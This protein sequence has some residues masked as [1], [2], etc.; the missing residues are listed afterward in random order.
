[1]AK[2]I[3]V[4]GAGGFGREVLWTLE[5]I[6]EKEPLWNILGF[7]DDDPKL[8][9]KHVEGYPVL[10]SIE[11][12]D[13]DYPG[14]AVFIGLGDN[15]LREKLYRR[16]RGHDFPILVDPSADVA[17]ASDIRH[18]TFIGPRAVVSVGTKIGKLVIVNARAGVGH[19]STLGDFSQVSPGASLSG[20]TTIG[21][22]AFI[23]TNACTAPGVKI[24]N[25]AKIAAGTPVY[26]NVAD[27]ETLSPFGTLK[28][29]A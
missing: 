25:G 23:A 24:G 19:D 5:R 9:G 29:Q 1:M 27:G 11:Q 17:A 6:N 18:G 14:A 28:G 8:A 2:D 4:I 21:D 10:G 22:S 7:A 26:S 12:A 20:H 13:R 3:I 16:L 15:A